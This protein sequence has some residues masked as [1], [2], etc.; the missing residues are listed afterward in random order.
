MERSCW[1]TTIYHICSDF[2]FMSVIIPVTKEKSFFTS[3]GNICFINNREEY[4]MWNKMWMDSWE[5][6]YVCWYVYSLD[7][8]EVQRTAAMLR[9]QDD[10]NPAKALW[11]LMGLIS[12]LIVKIW[13]LYLLYCS[14]SGCR[15]KEGKTP[16]DQLRDT[17]EDKE[18]SS[19]YLMCSV[20]AG[21]VRHQNKPHPYFWKGRV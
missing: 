15:E 9:V 14:T 8:S 1:T 16:L 4:L 13:S 19:Y 20:H 3:D 11:G 7:L 5:S 17:H 18:G 21:H 10:Y 2:N 6:R 12:L